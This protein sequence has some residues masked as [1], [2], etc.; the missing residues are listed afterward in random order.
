MLQNKTKCRE[1]QFSTDLDWQVHKTQCQAGIEATEPCWNGFGLAP[2][3]G[4]AAPL[5]WVQPGPCRATRC[6]ME[7][8][9]DE[10]GEQKCWGF[11]QHNTR[12]VLEQISKQ[13]KQDSSDVCVTWDDTYS[14]L[15]LNK[16]PADNFQ[17]TF[18]TLDAQNKIN[19]Y[20]ETLTKFCANS[21]L[22]WQRYYF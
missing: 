4:S 8:Q 13:G 22:L 16:R 11:S 12:V 2:G 1:A 6:V 15:L 20:S 21:I 7:Q 5:L 10:L 17:Q 18:L 14:C 3:S 9:R 19:T